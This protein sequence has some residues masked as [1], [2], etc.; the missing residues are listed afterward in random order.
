MPISVIIRKFGNITY[1]DAILIVSLAA[2]NAR[3]SH[4][5]VDSVVFVLETSG[6][7]IVLPE[8]VLPE[9]VLPE[10]VLPESVLPESVLPESVLPEFESILLL[11]VS[12]PDPLS[13]LP[14]SVLP[15]FIFSWISCARVCIS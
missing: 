15:V 14:E 1:P 6:S 12:V 2:L 5:F 4:E 11:I 13:I 10:S 3:S 9:S 7:V 8:S